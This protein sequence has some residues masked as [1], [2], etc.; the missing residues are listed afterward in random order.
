MQDFKNA[1]IADGCI[2]GAETV[3][4]KVF[5]EPDCAIAGNPAK[6]VKRG[7]T[8]DRATISEYMDRGPWTYNQ[9]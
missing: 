3:V 6:I 4:A 9:D 2:V 5:D 1:E 7:I 8:W